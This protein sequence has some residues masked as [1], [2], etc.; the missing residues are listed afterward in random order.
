MHLSKHIKYSEK[1]NLSSDV[2]AESISCLFRNICL[3][4]SPIGII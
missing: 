1:Y 2:L 4:V 3:A